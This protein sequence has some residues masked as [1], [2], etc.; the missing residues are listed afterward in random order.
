LFSYDNRP[1]TRETVT[2]ELRS[3][4]VSLEY[5]GNYSSHSFRRRAATSPRAVGLTDV[6][7]QLLGR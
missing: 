1:L 7:I 3:G 5:V 6:E 4:L 2:T